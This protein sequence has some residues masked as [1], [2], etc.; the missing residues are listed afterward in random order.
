MKRVIKSLNEMSFELPDSYRLLEDKYS[1]SNGQGFINTENYL[2]G[3][4][5]VVSFFEIHRQPDEF[6]K[7]Y[8]SL[9]KKYKADFEGVELAKNF[10]LKVGGY[11]CP[12]FIIKGCREPQMYIFQIFIDCGDC[13]GCFT[14]SIDEFDDDIKT[15]IDKNPILQELI[16]IMRSVQWK[17]C[18]YIVAVAH[19]VHRL[20]MF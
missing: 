9:T 10:T 17:S 16:D 6:V 18:C 12:V 14:V 2:S 20:L 4:G 5:K 3:N 8:T 19:A 13:V 11:R 15:L 7:Y 1:L